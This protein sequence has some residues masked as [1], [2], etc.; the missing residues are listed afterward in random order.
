MTR[1][2]ISYATSYFSKTSK[3][4]DSDLIRVSKS[5]FLMVIAYLLF[6][7]FDNF[8]KDNIALMDRLIDSL[9]FEKTKEGL[10]MTEIDFC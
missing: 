10:K 3:K 8:S 6:N 7:Q 9:F 5:D 2:I 4:T 1:A